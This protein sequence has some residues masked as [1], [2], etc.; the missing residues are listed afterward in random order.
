MPLKYFDCI[1]EVS[2]I[3]ILHIMCGRIKRVICVYIE[4]C[5]LH[6]QNSGKRFLNRVLLIAVL[7]CISGMFS[8]Y[9]DCTRKVY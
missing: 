5:Y 7:L 6:C 1:S 4:L 8:E 2:G 3:I 9:T